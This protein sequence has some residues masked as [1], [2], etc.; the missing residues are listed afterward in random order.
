MGV[1]TQTLPWFLHYLSYANPFKY[2]TRVLLQNELQGL[3][4]K[5]I[6]SE[7]KK[8]FCIFASG[9]QVLH[10][11]LMDNRDVGR[12][13]LIF[14]ALCVLYRMIAWAVIVIRVRLYGRKRSV[15]G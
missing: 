15:D 6:D 5:C 11:L 8:G 10:F 2:S 9:D 3:Q 13:L 14:S 12:D 4:I 1:M 7:I